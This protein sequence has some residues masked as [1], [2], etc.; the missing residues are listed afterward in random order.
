MEQNTD[1]KR[2]LVKTGKPR[3]SLSKFYLKHCKVKMHNICQYNHQPVRILNCD[4]KS[5]KI[6]TMKNYVYKCSFHITYHTTS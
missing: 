2:G 4:N 5:M 3:K 1:L 6:T